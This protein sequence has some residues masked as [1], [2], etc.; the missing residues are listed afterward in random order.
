MQYFY[1]YSLIIV[2]IR[3]FSC[4]VTFIVFLVPSSIYFR[5]NLFRRKMFD[6]NRPA[7]ISFKPVSQRQALLVIQF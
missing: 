2:Q 4:D 5:S 7:P 3:T 6:Y 1:N